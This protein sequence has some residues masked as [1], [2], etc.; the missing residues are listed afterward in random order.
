MASLIGDILKSIFY[1]EKRLVIVINRD[2]FLVEHSYDIE[3][4]YGRPVKVVHGTSLDLRLVREIDLVDNADMRYLFVADDDIEVVDDIQ[5]D[6]DIVTFNVQRLFNRYHWATIK[7]LSIDELQWL[8][9]QKQRVNLDAIATR[10]LLC[11]Y[12]ESVDFKQNALRDIKNVWNKIVENINF[13]KPSEFIPKL[14]R[15][16][17]QAIELDCWNELSDKVDELNT[18]FQ[19]FLCNYYNSILN[20]S[21]GSGTPKVVIQIAPYIHKQNDKKSALIVVDGMNVWQSIMLCDAIEAKLRNAKLEIASLY[22]WIPSVT[23]LS[24]QAIFKG[25]VPDVHFSQNPHTEQKSWENFWLDHRMPS[26][27]IYYQYGGTITPNYNTRR[28]GYVTI[29]IDKSLHNIFDY[30]YLYDFTRRWLDDESLVDD[31]INLVAD[32]Y[33]VYITSDH[34]NVETTPYRVLSQSDKVGAMHDNRYITLAAEA[35]KAM[36]EQ[37]YAGHVSQI[38]ANSRTYF[39]VNR[40]IFASTERKVTHGGTHWLEVFVPFITITNTQ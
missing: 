14:S 34:G 35:D 19:T 31:I 1:T 25:A 37:N 40:E 11:E 22:S 15:S 7:H 8:Y 23:E 6:A 21:I 38:D 20:S 26:S 13:K 36:F 32:G 12:R 2:R 17:L 4:A 10:N 33:R 18:K 3:N 39:A 27:N 28:L 16:M 24:R 5:E 9:E 29:D 30:M